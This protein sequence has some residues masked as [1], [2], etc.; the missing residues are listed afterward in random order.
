MKALYDVPAPAKLNL[1]LHVTGRRDDGYHLLQSVFMLIDWCDTL[2]FERRSDGQ[3]LRQDLSVKLPAE[4]LITRAARILQK[5]TGCKDGAA[6]AIEK[7]IPSQAGM[8]GGSSDAASC[9]L[10]LNRLWDLKLPLQTLEHLGLQLGAD[11]PFFLK[12]HNAWVEGVGEQIT[13][14]TLPPARFC[15]IKPAAGLETAQIFRDPH[16]NRATNPAIISDFAADHYGFGHNDLQ[17]V[18]EVLCPEVSQA[19]QCLKSAGMNGKMTGS[20]SAVFSRCHGPSQS[21]LVQVPERWLV[22]ECSNLEVHPLVGWA[23]SDN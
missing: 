2:H 10:A 8:G 13:P 21:N 17:P 6:I 23:S 22:Q 7:R 14:V 16:L 3:V 9:L 11:V 12:G 20:G 4:D 5:H 19:L 18:A 15:V 1:F